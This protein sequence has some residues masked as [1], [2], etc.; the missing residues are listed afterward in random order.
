[1]IILEKVDLLLGPNVLDENKK[2]IAHWVEYDDDT[3]EQLNFGFQE[4]WVQNK[5]FD[6]P[7]WLSE[8][9]PEMIEGVKNQWKNLDPQVGNVAWNLYNHILTV[10]QQAV[11]D[12]DIKPKRQSAESSKP[13]WLVDLQNS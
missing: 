6:D 13:Q 2:I 11:T 3:G 12:G 7:A 10:V 8:H 4:I 9:H 1:M 5:P